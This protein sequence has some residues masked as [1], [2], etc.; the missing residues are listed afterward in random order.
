MLTFQSFHTVT[1]AF[2]V[3]PDEEV[4]LVEDDFELDDD[5]DEDV[6]ILWS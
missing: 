3:L 2:S 4:L 5:F 1:Q 6:A